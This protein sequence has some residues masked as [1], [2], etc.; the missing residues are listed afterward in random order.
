MKKNILFICSN[1]KVGGFQKSLLSLL[2]H[3]DYRKYN[4]DLLLLDKGGIFTEFIPKEVRIIDSPVDKEYFESGK[5]AVI[6]MIKKGKLHL[7]FMRFISCVLWLFDKSVGAAFM[8]KAVP[9]LN[10]V[11]DAAIDYNGQHLLYYLVDKVNAKTKISYFHSDY[12]KWRYY[13]RA[14]RKYYAKVNAIVT[15]SEDC[16]TSMKDV[17]PEYADKIFCIENIN[18]EKTVNMFPIN[19]NGFEDRFKGIRLVTVGRVCKDKG[20]DFVCQ[21]LSLL[22][23]D[24]YKIRWYMVGP[25][26]NEKYCEHLIEEFDLDESMVMVGET[27]NPYEYIRNS[28]LFIHPSRFEGKSV[29]IEEAKILNKPIVV[30]DFSTVHNQ[31]IDKETGLIVDM[32]GKAVYEGI[33]KLIDDNELK[34]HIINRQRE[35]CHG[36]ESEVNKLYAL[37]D[38]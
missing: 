17:F 30:T 25:V 18:S 16:V 8:I 15:V 33:K 26:E 28:D 19:S 3:F 35:I 21:A 38:K 24:N 27:N 4:V 6:G 31:I 23:K 2:Q 32:N 10:K 37:I 5:S 29:A 1:M 36:N 13:E 12:K 11:Y 14:D 7:A 22:I 20:F 9:G 34:E